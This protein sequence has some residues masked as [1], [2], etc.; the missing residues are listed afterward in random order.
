MRVVDEARAA[1]AAGLKLI[2]TYGSPIMVMPAHVQEAVRVASLTVHP[3]HT[4]GTP[5]LRSVIA[6]TLRREQGLVADPDSELL[7]THGAMHGLNVT[8]RAL[9][10]AGDEIVVMA[11]TFFF[12]GSIRASGATPIYVSCEESDNW[13]WDKA[14]IEAAITTRTRAVMVC[15]P[16]NPTGFL[17]SQTDLEDLLDIASKHRLVVISDESYGRFVF[18]DE[19]YV[20]QMVLRERH[21][22]LVTITSLSKNYAFTN[23]RVGYV[24]AAAHLLDRIHREFEWDALDVGAVPQAAAAAVMSGPEDWLEGEY[25]RYESNRNIVHQGILEAGLT[26]VLSAAGPFMLVNF[27]RAGLQGRVLEGA[28]LQRGIA[29]V[30][31]DGFKGPATHARI[32]FGGSPEVLGSIISALRDVVNEAR[33]D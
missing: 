27:A 28:L 25:S 17:P 26:A 19:T 6:A 33:K 21:P 22:D 2:P 23:W 9:L 7:V 29:T 14:R 15:N 11:P 13:G 31:G 12:D 5:E 30:A 32:S 16:T 3:R 10:S 4:R 24:H 8:F 18:D 1:E 20:P